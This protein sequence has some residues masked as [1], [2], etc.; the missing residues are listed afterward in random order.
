MF[1]V[2]IKFDSIEELMDANI[3]GVCVYGPVA[4]NPIHP[5]YIANNIV[6]PG[7]DDESVH[8]AR[9]SLSHLIEFTAA[10]RTFHIKNVAHIPD[11]IKVLIE[12]MDHQKKTMNINNPETALYREGCHKL[13][14][15]LQNYVKVKEPIDPRLAG[16]D[17]V[18]KKMKQTY[19]KV[20]K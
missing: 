12:Y 17:T 3:H 14:R 18:F 11:M 9:L 19:K 1:D 16:P 2:N 15:T 5:R 8:H 6:P 20:G 4:G 13:I 7:Y 10:E